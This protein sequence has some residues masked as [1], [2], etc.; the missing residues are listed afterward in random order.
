MVLD[1]KIT[2]IVDDKAD[3]SLIQTHGLSLLI[4]YNDYYVLFDTGPSIEVLEHNAEKLGVDLELV[5][6]VVLSHTHTPHIGGIRLLGWSSPFIKVYAPYGSLEFIS[7]MLKPLGVKPVEIDSWKKLTDKI[8]I[9]KPIHGPP[10][11][12]FLVINTSKGL[13]V[14][15]GCMHPGIKRVIDE[16]T[17]FLKEHRI[18]GLIGG[19][20]LSNA[21]QTVI[22]EV[23]EYIEELSPEY[24]IP[25]HCSGDKFR[26]ELKKKLPDTLYEAIAGEIIEF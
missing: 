23:I 21:P 3:N 10:W 16:I 7:N 17:G 26:E 14:F 11:E 6:A 8:Y 19:F 15:S 2:V 5:D 25:L 24:I 12:H 20:H 13:L 4:E 1:L 18:Y 22:N 9:S